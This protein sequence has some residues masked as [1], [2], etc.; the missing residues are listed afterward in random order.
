MASR[1]IWDKPSLFFY[2][3]HHVSP[4]FGLSMTQ[5]YVFRTGYAYVCLKMCQN[6]DT[7]LDLGRHIPGFVRL[8][9]VAAQ[10][11]F[12]TAPACAI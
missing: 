7:L 11:F 10:V 5:L 9:V 3:T 4:R 1:N 6:N 8:V 2:P 12:Q